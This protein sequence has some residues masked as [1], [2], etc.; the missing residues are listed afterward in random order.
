MLSEHGPFVVTTARRTERGPHPSG[1]EAFGLQIRFPWQRSGRR[2]ITAPRERVVQLARNAAR[3]RARPEQEIAGYREVLGTIHTDHAH[4]TLSKG[5]VQQ[6]HRDLFPARLH[7]C[8]SGQ[9]G[10]G[11][12]K[13]KPTRKAQAKSR[14]FTLWTVQMVM[15]SAVVS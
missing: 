14:P 8:S 7:S 4:M 5:L 11:S 6:L 10:P 3:P 1:Q 15:L 9:F 2:T 13:S 12:R